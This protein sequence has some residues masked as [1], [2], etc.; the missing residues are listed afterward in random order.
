MPISN[1]FDLHTLGPCTYL[2]VDIS[3][4]DVSVNETDSTA[5]FAVSL[6][7]ASALEVT[8]DYA[9]ADA[10]A[11]AG[12]D[13]SG[14]SGTVTFLPGETEQ[15][16]DIT[17]LPDGKGE[18]D[19]TFNLQLSAP[20]NA[21]ISDALATATIVDDE[22]SACGEP[23][24]DPSSERGMFIWNDCQGDNI[25]NIRMTA[26]GDYGNY[27]GLITS[28]QPFAFVAPV[29]IEG[30]DVLE[31][32]GTG[33]ISYHL[34]VWGGAIDG[35]TFSPANGDDELCFDPE[36]PIDEKVILGND[37]IQLMPPLDLQDLGVCGSDVTC[38]PAN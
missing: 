4:A 3:V 7:T 21:I 20:V 12:L 30:G 33:E 6:A 9:T 5:S 17:I 16:V 31:D 24:F 14:D 35:V 38:H 15:T 2:P 23:D 11:T 25:W 29:D 34:Q 19:E 27:Q 18:I 26:G 28:A 36:I 32:S 1:P 13:Y 8:V 22:V 37:R 10:T